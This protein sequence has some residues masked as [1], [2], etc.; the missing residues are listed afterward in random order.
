MPTVEPVVGVAG[1]CLFAY[2][3]AKDMRALDQ[4]TFPSST[5]DCG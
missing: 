3:A 5:L 4:V 1:G 2:L